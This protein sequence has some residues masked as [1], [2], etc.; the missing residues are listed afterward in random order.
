MCVDCV[1]SIGVVPID[2]NGIYLASGVSGKG[3]ASYPGLSFVLYNHDVLPSESIPRYLD[4]GYYAQ[5]GGVPFT[6]S[7]NLVY[8]LGEAL[9]TL[10]A[11]NRYKE[12]KELSNWAR[13]KITEIGFDIV[14]TDDI[15]TPGLITISLPQWLNSQDLGERLEDRGFLLHWRSQY[16]IDRNWIQIAFMSSHCREEI[17][18]LM[19]FLSDL[20]KPLRKAL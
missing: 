5:S 3:L 1:S 6:L 12:I 20:E 15:A 17:V 4:L 14:A 19:E 2:L 10:N 13:V 16:L 8:A 11:P 9:K 7:S 18:P